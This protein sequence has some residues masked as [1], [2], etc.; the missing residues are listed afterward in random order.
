MHRLLRL[1]TV[2]AARRDRISSDEEERRRSGFELVTSYRFADHGAKPGRVD[3][4]AEVDGEPVL[5]LRYGDTATVRVTNLGLRRRKDGGSDG[6]YIDVRTGRWLSESKALEVSS[7]DELDEV[8]TAQ[9]AQKVIPYVE[10]RRNVLV[11]RLAAGPVDEVA[12]ISFMYALERGIEAEFLL[13]DSELSSELLPDGSGL[14][15]ALFVE[16]AEGGAGVLRRLVEEA[17]ALRRAARRALRIA[18][19]DP[20]SGEDEGGVV[21][22]SSERCARACYDCLLSYGNQGGHLLIDRHQARDLLLACARSTTRL[23][24]TVADPALAWEPL[25]GAVEGDPPRQAFLAWLEEREHRRPDE[26]DVEVAGCQARPDLVYRLAAG[27]VAVFVDGPD[28]ADRPRRDE[29]AEDDLRDAGWSVVRIPY[30]ADYAEIVARYPSVFG[31][32]GRERR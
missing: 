25:R 29:P 31:S 18:H 2:K 6:Y 27:D 28:D 3:A 13:E 1:Q 23:A 26:L 24:K 5:D 4:S 21:E 30:G 12:A 9:A 8:G 19:F 11:T 16:S 32:S 15:R 20:D 17:D 22:G 14:G 7:E 10:D